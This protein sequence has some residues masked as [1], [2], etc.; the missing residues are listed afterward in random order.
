MEWRPYLQTFVPNTFREFVVKHGFDSLPQKQPLQD[1][2]PYKPSAREVEMQQE[3]LVE[4]KRKVAKQRLS[5]KLHV[6]RP[7]IKTPTL[8]D[9]PATISTIPPRKVRTCSV[10]DKGSLFV[11]TALSALQATEETMGK[12]KGRRQ[13]TLIV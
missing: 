10:D 9:P 11:L 6:Q 1:L 5:I 3:R 2:L 8:K 12:P 4:L 13:S 7:I